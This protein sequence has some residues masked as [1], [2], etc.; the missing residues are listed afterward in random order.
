[1]EVLTFRPYATA[2]PS[3][4]RSRLGLWLD[5]WRCAFRPK[6]TR[7]RTAGRRGSSDPETLR[8]FCSERCDAARLFPTSGRSIECANF[9]Q[10]AAT[11]TSSAGNVLILPHGRFLPIF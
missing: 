8:S 10:Y 2:P 9:R 6:T 4:N 11:G 1:D 3:A 7:C 5:L